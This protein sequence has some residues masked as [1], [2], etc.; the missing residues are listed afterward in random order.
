MLFTC[1]PSFLVLM[2]VHPVLPAVSDREPLSLGW[3]NTARKRYPT[4]Q[5]PL[6]R[7][8]CHG[9]ELPLLCR[10][11]VGSTRTRASPAAQC[12]EPAP[13]SARGGR[14]RPATRPGPRERTVPTGSESA[15]VP[16]AIVAGRGSATWADGAAAPSHVDG[17]QAGQRR[18]ADGGAERL[19]LQA[20]AVGAAV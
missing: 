15:R 1:R 16:P 10:A 13:V 2:Y 20:V 14:S 12:P 8:L 11:R 17:L 3:P 5:A 4:G 9:T 18:A 19:A 6:T 7:P